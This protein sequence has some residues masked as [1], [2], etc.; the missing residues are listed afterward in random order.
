MRN[1]YLL[2]AI[3]AILLLGYD[4]HAQERA[5]TIDELFELCDN[6][7][8][9]VKISHI[10]A[11]QAAEG[12]KAAKSALL[13]EV[14]TS[15]SVSFLGDGC[16]VERDFKSG[17]NADMPHWGNNFA[18]KASQVI[19]AGGAISAGIKQAKIEKE[20]AEQNIILT[21]QNMRFLLLGYYLE[22]FKLNNRAMVLEKN[23]E[24]ARLLLKHIEK[25][26]EQGVTLKN[27]ITRYELQLEQLLL[28]L[29][30]TKN[31]TR[32]INHRI[33]STLNLPI[34]TII[35]PDSALM[36]NI[37]PVRSIKEWQE[38][39][40]NNNPQ[41]QM[42]SL[43]LSLQKQ[44]E[45]TAKA[46]KL[47]QVA[48]VAANHF[49]GPITIEVPTID[50]NFNYWYVG[51]GVRYNLSSLWKANKK[52]RIERLGTTRAKESLNLA[53]EENEIAMNNAY[54]MFEQATQHLKTQEKSVELATQNYNVVNNRYLN[55]LALI[56]DMIDASNAKLNAQLQLVNARINLIYSYHNLKRTAGTL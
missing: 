31:N 54:I 2:I 5:V 4:A 1:F 17:T 19:Y 15:L 52:C 40:D 32:I 44:K 51:L 45:K 28:L 26:Y 27:D 56:T 30:D 11:L 3:T 38:C 7:C 25:K 24:Q 49:D 33:T 47:P 12:V 16:I 14:E 48:L 23:I 22:L 43:G 53:Q 10:E 42:A 55:D 9:S 18:I 21:K 36:N 13:P 29:N 6:N 35:V 41:L 20:I 34:G 50:K 8:S 37:L 46:A 39:A